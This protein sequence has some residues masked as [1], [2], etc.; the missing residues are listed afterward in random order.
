MPM[1]RNTSHGSSGWVPRTNV[2]SN[3]SRGDRLAVALADRSHDT[4]WPPV[5]RCTAHHERPAAASA[6]PVPMS[7]SHRLRS[8]NSSAPAMKKAP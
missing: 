5:V 3:R 7:A 6:A 4:S 8:V 1:H 2:S